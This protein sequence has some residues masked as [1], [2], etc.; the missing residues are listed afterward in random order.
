MTTLRQ[1][2]GGNMPAWDERLNDNEIK[3]LTAYVHS[4]GGGQ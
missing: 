3:I 2:R 1:G 4:L